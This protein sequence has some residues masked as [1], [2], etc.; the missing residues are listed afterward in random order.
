MQ[1]RV[2]AGR[3]LFTALA[4]SSLFAC[5]STHERE[6]DFLRS[7]PLCELQPYDASAA[8]IERKVMFHR[9]RP[10]SL[11]IID[12]KHEA[13]DYFDAEVQEACSFSIDPTDVPDFARYR[14]EKVT[15]VG[16]YLPPVVAQL[17]KLLP[18]PLESIHRSP[19]TK[20][21]SYFD[22]DRRH[23]VV[24]KARSRCPMIEY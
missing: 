22:A 11:R 3:L 15:R 21:W 5:S 1:R 13:K 24:M 2:P 10:P 20:E 4:I 19:G 12:C 9:R 17:A 18:Q 16:S 8:A 14:D 7:G 6:D 23:G